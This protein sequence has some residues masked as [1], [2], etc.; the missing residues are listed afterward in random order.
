MALDWYILE[1]EV[2]AK[3]PPR[4][5]G[6]LRPLQLPRDP[7]TRVA[8]EEHDHFAMMSRCGNLPL[9]GRAADYDRDAVY[10]P[11]EVAALIDELATAGPL[12]GAAAGVAALCAEA[13]H[14]RCGLV[15]IAD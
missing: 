5:R 4:R 2:A 9:L 12:S 8:M 13:C 7:A 10:A 15:A 14:R 1:P 11:T 6:A 3:P